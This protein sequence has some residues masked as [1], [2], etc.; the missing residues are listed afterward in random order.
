ML[1]FE[2]ASA[3]FNSNHLEAF[4]PKLIFLFLIISPWR[5]PFIHDFYSLFLPT[6][7]HL[8]TITQIP[9]TLT[10]PLTT[11]SRIHRCRRT[12]SCSLL[13]SFYTRYLPHWLDHL[14][15]MSS[16]IR[17]YCSRMHTQRMQPLSTETPVN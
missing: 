6:R 11:N 16:Q 14:A 4:H 8:H 10:L 1:V 12:L 17:F 2:S 13:S 15:D 9:T 3:L 7:T 5:I